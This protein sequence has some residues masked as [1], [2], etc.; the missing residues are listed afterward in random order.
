[1]LCIEITK[2]EKQKHKVTYCSPA[3]VSTVSAVLIAVVSA[4]VVVVLHHLARPEIEGGTTQGGRGHLSLWIGKVARGAID[5]G[6]G[7]GDNL[8]LSGETRG[9]VGC[10][11]VLRASLRTL[12]DTAGAIVKQLHSRGIS[13][14]ASKSNY[15]LSRLCD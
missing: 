13:V 1:M 2:I 9:G 15:S 14:V 6:V 4:A 3:Y 7:D 10:C 5:A 12:L 8:S 11:R